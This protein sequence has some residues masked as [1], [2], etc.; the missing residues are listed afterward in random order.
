[1]F[2]VTI[3]SDKLLDVV[4]L[5]Y[6]NTKRVKINFDMVLS[7]LASF[8]HSPFPSFVP[9]S[10]APLFHKFGVWVPHGPTPGHSVF[11]V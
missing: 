10:S 1:M 8:L 3:F 2:H 7:S 5:I 9:V 6:K 4:T 11:G